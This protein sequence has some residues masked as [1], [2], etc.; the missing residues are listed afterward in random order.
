MSA[1]TFIAFDMPSSS[2]GGSS[3]CRS[4]RRRATGRSRGAPRARGHRHRGLTS[5][6]TTPASIAPVGST[7][8]PQL[9]HTVAPG[10]IGSPHTP[11]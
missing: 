11:Q 3:R 2:L 7:A 1:I 6:D 5:S 9:P 10:S 4:R 8:A